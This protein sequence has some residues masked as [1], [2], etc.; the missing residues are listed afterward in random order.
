MSFNITGDNPLYIDASD[1][2]GKLKTMQRIMCKE[3]YEKLLYRTLKEVGAKTRTITW[4]EIKH[5]YEVK[6]KWVY[7]SFGKPQTQMGGY[8]QFPVSCV[9]PLSGKKG[10]LGPTFKSSGGS[11]KKGRM[12]IVKAR[13]VKTGRSTLP[14]KMPRDM[15]GQKPFKSGGIVWRRLTDK[16]LPI[17][18]VSGVA[19][20]QMPLNRS[21][22]DVV[23]ELLAYMEDRLDHNFN[24]ILDQELGR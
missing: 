20:P 24:Y 21:K 4:N 1:M 23:K 13:I 16:R 18:V 12:H 11:N 10:V 22:D 5:D 6:R 19:V 7:S 8:G 2:E 14:E 9:I 3:Q 15:G 17:A